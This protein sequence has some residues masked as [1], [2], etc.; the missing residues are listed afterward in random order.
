MRFFRLGQFS[1]D[2]EVSAY[3]E[4][5]DWGSFLDIQ[6]DLLLRIMEIVEQEGT[7]IALPSQTLK[8]ADAGS[9]A[10][11]PRSSR[12]RGRRVSTYAAAPLDVELRQRIA[13]A[14]R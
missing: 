6:Q 2:I 14:P 3:I 10:S 12:R 11:L 13:P 4:V 9:A 5:S 8:L 1:L 7:A